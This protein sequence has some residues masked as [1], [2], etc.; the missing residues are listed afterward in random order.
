MLSTAER[1]LVEAATA[2][3]VNAHRSDD[4]S[5]AAA[6]MDSAGNVFTGVNVFH[7]T[8]GPCAEPVAVGQAVAAA[9]AVLP[10]T[11][12]AAVHDRGVIAPC[13]RCRQILFDLYPGIRAVIRTKIGHEAV[14]VRELL[15]FVFD[16]RE[17]EPGVPQT[18]YVWEGYLDAIRAGTKTSTVRVDDPAT[19]GPCRLV[20][21][22]DSEGT[23]TT[24]LVEITDV[25]EGTA[26]EL[27]DD[28][29]RRDGF[30]DLTGLTTALATHYPGIEDRTKV[31]VVHF[32][33]PAS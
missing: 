3:L 8:G 7:F 9:E 1:R 29:A 11:C 22:H 28:D 19:V 23:T 21:D 16:W 33:L 6:A 32:R 30:A 10:L 12:I 17:L 20:F 5:V 27:T 15:P 2:T 13:G 4:H 31:D 24:Q 25:V 18:L 14:P 26:G